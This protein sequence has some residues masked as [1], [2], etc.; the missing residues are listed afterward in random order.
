VPVW[1]NFAPANELVEVWQDSQLALVVMWLA[2]FPFAVNPLWQLAQLPVTPEW[3]NRIAPEKL[4][5]D[6]WQ[7]SQEAFV[8]M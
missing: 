5:V 2:D 6:L 8:S 4:E 7:V 3:S 1:L